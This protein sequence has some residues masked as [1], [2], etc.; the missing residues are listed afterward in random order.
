MFFPDFYIEQLYNSCTKCT[1][2]CTMS[3]GSACAHLSLYKEKNSD[4]D[5]PPS[6]ARG[7]LVN[8]HA[9]TGGALDDIKVC[10]CSMHQFS[11]M[12]VEDMLN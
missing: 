3:Y 12:T 6:V 1:M 7:D 5:Q 2:L 9:K 8:E 11:Y 4:G 10:H